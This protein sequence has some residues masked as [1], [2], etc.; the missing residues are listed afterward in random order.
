MPFNKIA[1]KAGLGVI[2]CP[3][4]NM[5]RSRSNE[6]VRRW[7]KARESPWIGHS[8]QVMEDNYL[9]SMD[10]DFLDASG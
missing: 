9:D 4:T 5:R 10:E 3:F 1:Y 6:V 8:E 2:E 7:G